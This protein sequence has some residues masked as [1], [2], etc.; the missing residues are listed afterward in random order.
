MNRGI[1]LFA[2]NN[3]VIDY[4]L[5]SVISAGL[6]K[7]YLELPVS[8][9]TDKNTVSNMKESEY[10]NKANDIFDKIII[11]DKPETNNRRKLNNASM[12]FVNSNRSSVWELTPYDHTL[13]IDS[14]FLIFSNKLNQCWSNAD[15]SISSGMLDLKGDREGILDKR[16]SDVGVKMFWATTVIFKKNKS[17]KLFFDL[18]T[19]VKEN[20]SFYADVFSFDSRQYRNDISFS[21][22]KHILDGFEENTEYSLPNIFTVLDEDI[23]VDIDSENNLIFLLKNKDS[24][25]ASATKGNDIHVLNKCSIIENKEKFFKLI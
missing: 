14:D 6:A 1:I 12:A 4:G 17:S 15:V 25:L 7:K 22:A 21:I 23:F 2:H 5:L 20:Y 13:L 9:I 10:F 11:V 16:V 19:H 3:E 18:V 24:Y 8:L